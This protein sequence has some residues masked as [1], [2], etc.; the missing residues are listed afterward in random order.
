MFSN[1]F[2]PSKRI[3]IFPKIQPSISEG[4]KSTYLKLKPDE[5]LI[6][7]FDETIFARNAKDGF[8]FTTKRI[9][10]RNLT[11]QPK[12]I[13]YRNISD[14]VMFSLT[15]KTQL[16]LAEGMYISIRFTIDDNKKDSLIQFL[17]AVRT[18]YK[19][20]V[21][22]KL[23]TESVSNWFLTISGKEYGP[24]DIDTIKGMLSSGQLNFSESLVWRDGMVN[25]TPFMKV[26]E[27]AEL[28]EPDKKDFP[29]LLKLLK[30]PSLPTTELS[31]LKKTTNEDKSPIDLNN[32]SIDDLLGLPG[33]NI[34]KAKK[35]I[36]ERNKR[37][38]FTSIED[39]GMFL[40]FQ[41]HQVKILKENAVLNPYQ[42]KDVKPLKG[43]IVDF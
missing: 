29:P 34:V 10:W 38:G 36:E 39:V 28:L 17:K 41:P 15:S 22:Q 1:L 14:A 26:Q 5:L 30:K 24:Y 23:Q 4:A 43:R 27:M 12:E 20:G 31:H 16:E 42:I 8:A 13:E 7:I 2:T 18:S 37:G 9:Y 3:F 19:T 21:L 33:I 40:Y 25:W 35:I 6:A 32:A 11:E